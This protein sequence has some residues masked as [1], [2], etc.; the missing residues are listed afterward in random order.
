VTTEADLSLVTDPRSLSVAENED[1]EL[2]SKTDRRAALKM[3]TAVPLGLT[4]SLAMAGNSLAQPNEVPSRTQ[5]TVAAIEPT[6]GSWSTWILASGNELR[7]APPPDTGATQSELAALHDLAARRDAAMLDRI[8]YWDAGAPS[9][10]WTQRA[11]KHTQSKGVFGNRAQRMLAL[12][13][14]AIYDGMIAA[15]DSKYAH[16]RTRPSPAAGAPSP[17]I[18]TPNSPSYPDE[19]AVAAGAA[20]T[21]LGYIFPA[22]AAMFETLADEAARSRLEAGVAYPS[23]V[24]AGLALGRQVGER[25]V[26]WGRSDGSDTAWTGSV[27]TDPGRWSGTN[28]AEPSAGSWKPL[29]LSSGSQLRPASPAPLDSE[30]FARELAEVKSYARTNLTNV[31]AGYWEYYGGRA[32]FEFWNDQASKKVFEYRLDTNPPRAA[33]VYALVNAASHDALIAGW[34]AKYT[35]WSPRPHMVDPTIT[36]VVAAPNHPSYPSAHSVWSGAAGAVLGRLFPRDA[37]YFGSLAQEAGEARIMAGIHYRSD[38]EAG[39]TMGRQVAEVVWARART[40]AS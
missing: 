35:Y 17:A 37:E 16:G 12:L 25:A 29:M 22:D 38:C 34:D 21:V 24:E 2:S 3:L 8:S 20:S 19:H 9:Y 32:A 39:L 13:N 14:V 36:T 18:P 40:D 5:A 26:S 4:A 31:T 11:V 33:L 28:P 6:A 7:L 15:W 1:I 30:Q 10:R 23:D 27:P